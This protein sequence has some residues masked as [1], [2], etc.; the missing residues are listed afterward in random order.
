MVLEGSEGKGLKSQ[1]TLADMKKIIDQHN[2]GRWSYRESSMGLTVKLADRQITIEDRKKKNPDFKNK[3]ETP[4]V[5]QYAVKA[6]P[7]RLDEVK[8]A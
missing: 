8:T 2:V 1:A 6:G 7:I 4:D 3:E 5:P